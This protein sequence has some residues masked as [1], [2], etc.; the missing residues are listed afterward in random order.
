[1]YYTNDLR[2]HLNVLYAVL[3]LEDSW[4]EVRLLYVLKGISIAKDATE[5]DSLINGNICQSTTINN[6]VYE[7][8]KSIF[9]MIS[10]SKSCYQKRAYHFIKFLVKLITK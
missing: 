10:K 6:N 5:I 3:T 7:S 2:V 1:V 9:E 8:S 4:Q